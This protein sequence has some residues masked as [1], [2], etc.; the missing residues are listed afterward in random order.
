MTRR[1]EPE[2]PT[3]RR[4]RRAADRLERITAVARAEG[5]SARHLAVITAARI[6]RLQARAGSDAT[7]AQED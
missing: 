6:A 7:P 1:P 2:T 5:A 4:T 3:E